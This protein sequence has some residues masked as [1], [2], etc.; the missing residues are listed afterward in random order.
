MKDSI[1]VKLNVGITAYERGK[2]VHRYEGHNIWLDLGRIYLMQVISAASFGPDV[3]YRTDL[4]KYIGLGIGGTKQYALGVANAAPLSSSYPG[5]NV[6]TDADPTLTRLERPVRVSGSITSPPY[7]DPSD[8]WLGQIQAPP[9]FGV[10]PEVTY[11]RVFTQTEI[12]YGPYLQV[13][14]SEVALFTSLITPDVYNN[15]PIAYETFPTIMKTS[16]MD[17]EIVWTL[18]F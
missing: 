5:T 2:V 9:T 11:R 12:S 6:Y 1:E 16:A 14:L 13:P 10:T 3:P 15:A 17:L 4:V 8:I 18:H 7:S